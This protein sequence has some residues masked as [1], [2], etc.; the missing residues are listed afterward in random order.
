MK[1]MMRAA[2]AGALVAALAPALVLAKDKDKEKKE[3]T[4][5]VSLEASVLLGIGVSVGTSLG[6]RFN[7][8]GAYH[9][10]TYEREMEGD[11]DEADY[12]AEL[13][14]QSAALLLDWHP[15]KGAFRLTG[16]LMQNG[17][18]INLTGTAKSGA[19]Y[20]VGDCTFES[21]PND[22]L[23]INGVTD[24]AGTAPY[25]GMGWGG[26]MNAAPGFFATFDLG[27]MFSGSPDTSLKGR[28][29][30]RNADVTQPQCGDPVNYSDVS[31]YQEFQDEIEKAED[32]A[33]E[34]SEDFK[35]WPNIAFGLG[36]RF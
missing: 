18:Q 28:G 35:L 12:D 32:E 4:V 25:L 15:F 9:A 7:V 17:N 20:D 27:V 34:E 1:A 11:A 19:T 2:C 14:L 33:N 23:R 8:R 10:F 26:N 21:D 24:F 3:T 30:A 13:D 29:S 36:W 31:G 16:G 22:P 5:G 6:D